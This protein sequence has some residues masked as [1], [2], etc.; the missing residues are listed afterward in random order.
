MDFGE[1]ASVSVITVAFVE[2]IREPS[3]EGGNQMN[4][5]QTRALALGFAVTLQFL[6]DFG[7]G[8]IT[9]YQT[10]TMTIFKGITA[11]IAAT[12]SVAVYKNSK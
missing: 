3:S 1:V 2:M 4:K 6:W 12:G 11:G 8:Q 7:N 5:W 10:A 9:D